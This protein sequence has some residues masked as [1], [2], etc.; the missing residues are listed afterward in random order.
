[1]RY[2]KRM[3]LRSL[4]APRVLITAGSHPDLFG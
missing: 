1:M 3:I 4:L 2:R